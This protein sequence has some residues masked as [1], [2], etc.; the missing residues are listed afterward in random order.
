MST[1]VEVIKVL[2]FDSETS[3]PGYDSIAKK[4]YVTLRSTNEVAEI[5]PST[6]RAIGRYPV[7]GCGFDPGMA[8]DSEHHRVFLLCGQT[9]NLTV[10]SLDGHKATLI[11]RSLPEQML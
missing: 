10:F 3:T 11:S 6:D 1:R 9:H 4:I 2:R 7:E 5:D 8:V